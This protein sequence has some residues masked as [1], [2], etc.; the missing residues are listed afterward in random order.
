VI[1]ATRR[2]WPRQTARLGREELRLSPVRRPP[3]R[4]GGWTAPARHREVLAVGIN[5]D[6]M[7][8]CAGVAPGQA[9]IA[10]RDLQHARTVHNG[11]AVEKFRLDG[12]GITLHGHGASPA[13]GQ[14]ASSLV[15]GIGMDEHLAR[16]CELR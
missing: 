1:T 15:W 9:A 16:V 6:R 8:C 5:P 10:A 3:A 2:A 12:F 14:N 13:T 7:L 4:V 11:H